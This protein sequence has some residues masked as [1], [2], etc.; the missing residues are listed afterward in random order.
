MAGVGA[1]GGK[2]FVARR[3]PGGDL[4]ERWEFPGGK[5]REGESD[6]AALVREFQEE[7]AVPVEPGAF[8]G[9]TSFVHHETVFT[10]RAY[11]VRFVSKDFTLR[12]HSEWRWVSPG[13]LEALDF[14]PS[15]RALFPAL[16]RALGEQNKQN[17]QG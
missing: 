11:G 7:F 3:L 17:E 1:E 15:D 13:E 4:G 6:G 5:V 16:W 12:V 2:L 9:E 10:L 14:A 8:I